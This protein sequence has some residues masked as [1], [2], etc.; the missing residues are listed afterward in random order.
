LLLTEG[1]RGAQD[2]GQQTR[3]DPRET[4][5]HH[6]KASFWT[7]TVML[8]ISQDVGT[9]A[10]GSD[11]RSWRPP[12]AD[13]LDCL[14]VPVPSRLSESPHQSDSSRGGTAASVSRKEPGHDL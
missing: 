10:P 5:L 12:M 13:H 11:G 3:G 1:V 14:V 6:G 8:G 4:S 9:K 2:Q 7:T